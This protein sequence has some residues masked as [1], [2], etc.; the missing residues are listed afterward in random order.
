MES[1]DE[2]IAYINSVGCVL[3]TFDDTH[4]QSCTFHVGWIYIKTSPMWQMQTTLLQARDYVS[5]RCASGIVPL[6]LME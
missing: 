5:S 4:S 1:Y 3:K 6:K 2:V